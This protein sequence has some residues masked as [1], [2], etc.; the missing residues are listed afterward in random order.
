M[1]PSLVDFLIQKEGRAQLP[2]L[3]LCASRNSFDFIFMRNEQGE[4][5]TL[6]IAHRPKPPYRCLK[7]SRG[8]PNC[9]SSILPTKGHRLQGS[10][11]AHQ[12][13]LT[14]TLSSR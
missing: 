9:Y 3:L 12:H 8:V 11:L 7:R 13:A 1:N 14:Q 4:A 6:G 2:T 10:I 5:S